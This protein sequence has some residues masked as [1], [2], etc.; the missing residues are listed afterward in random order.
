VLLSLCAA[1][2]ENGVIGRKGGLPWSL[3]DE[4]AHFVRTTRGKPVIMGRRT[5]ES[6]DK[7]LRQRLNVVLSRDSSYVAP[8]AT[9]VPDLAAAIVLVGDVP[10]AVVIGG[11]QIYAQALPHAGRMYLT[12][13]HGRPEGDTFFPAFDASQWQRT[14]LQE[15]PADAR[16]EFAFTI[17]QLDR[18]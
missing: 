16:H 18:K 13:V 5:F 7:A 3:P 12:T 6:F 1:V 9:V 4:M 11:A 15:H 14:V 10:E 17:C 2:A 8:N